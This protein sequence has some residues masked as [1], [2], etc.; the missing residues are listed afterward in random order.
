MKK[1]LIRILSIGIISLYVFCGC[2][3]ES[4]C[5]N[6]GQHLSVYQT[7]GGPSPLQVL[8]IL[9][10]VNRDCSM[11]VKEQ[12]DYFYCNELNRFCRWN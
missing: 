10:V 9:Y 6:E 2:S 5:I 12:E 1:K 8:D 11:T 4:L 7:S 3:K